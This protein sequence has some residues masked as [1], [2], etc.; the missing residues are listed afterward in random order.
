MTENP[1]LPL[2]A[3]L[4]ELGISPE[5]LDVVHS[6][7][8]DLEKAKGIVDIIL[9]LKHYFPGIPF[10]QVL[11]NTSQNPTESLELFKDGKERHKKEPNN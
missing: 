11:S 2:S 8:K 4:H 10:L 1:K 6:L 7:E 5:G 3:M 9:I